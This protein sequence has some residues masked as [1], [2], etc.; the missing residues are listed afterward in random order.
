LAYIQFL[1]AAGTVTGS[2]HLINTTHDSSGKQGFQVLIDCGLFQGPKEWRER[3]WQDTPVPAREIDAAILTHAHLDHCGW[4]PRLV[5]GG[6]RGPIYATQPTI[7]LCSVVLPDSGHLQEEDAAFY[8]KRKV[9]KHDPALPLYTLDEAQD[10]LKYFKPVAVGQ[11]TQ[12][13]PELAFRF[14]PAAHILG[15]CMAEITL[16]TAGRS[17]RLLFTG[18]VG[19][20]RDSQIAPGKV[21][22]SGPQENETADLLVMESTYGNRQHPLTDPRPILAGLIRETVQRG[23]SVIVPAFAVERTQK[24]LFML[25]EL[26]ETGQTPRLPVYCDSPM[27]IKAVE[28]FLK[29]SAE[30]TPQAAELIKKYGS[31]IEWPGFTFTQTV[32]QSKKINASP[33]PSIIVSSSGMV[34]GGRIL[35][36]LAQRLPDP[37]NL[38]IF[39]GFQAPGTRGAIIKNGGSEVK[40]FGEFVP[41]RARVAALE[42]FSDHADPPELLEWLRTF[43]NTPAATYLV[44]GEPAASS[45]LRDRMKKELGWNVEVAEYME[46][47]EVK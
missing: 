5:K 13:S 27:A 10:C 18:D 12:L 15:S 2:K 32:E 8:N 21:V 25:K 24:F 1:G 14:V 17:R 36:H 39:I 23:G 11:T 30:Y 29:H 42:Q 40:I 16:Q 45:Q 43:K 20:V 47:V 19:R 38:V 35:H 34:T 28:I 33:F 41:I 7:D 26:M 31:P 44:H 9:S 46:R 6:F 22:H 37:K 4:I 3:N